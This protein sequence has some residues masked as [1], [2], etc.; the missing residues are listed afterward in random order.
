MGYSTAAVMALT[1]VVV[2]PKFGM[3]ADNG[4]DET[5]LC[6]AYAFCNSLAP[7]MGKPRGRFAEGGRGAGGATEP[8]GPLLQRLASRVPSAFPPS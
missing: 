8:P 5:L 7:C 6:L 4:T 2:V 1:P 3:F